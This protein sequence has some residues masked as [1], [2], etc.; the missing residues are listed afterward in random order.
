[1]FSVHSEEEAEALLVRACPRNAQ[2]DFVAEE[3]AEEQDLARLYA[4]GDRLAELYSR[5]SSTPD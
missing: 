2:G 5:T 4:F 1:M 3:L